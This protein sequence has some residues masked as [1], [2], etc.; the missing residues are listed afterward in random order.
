MHNLATD[1]WL[2][3]IQEK[4]KTKGCCSKGK[5]KVEITTVS[6][7]EN[8]TQTRINRSKQIGSGKKEKTPAQPSSLY[9][10][11]ALLA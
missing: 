1:K 10:E 11:T 8:R 2:F 5:D 4:E 9:K 3:S 7:D 6:L